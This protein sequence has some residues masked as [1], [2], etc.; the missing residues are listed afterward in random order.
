MR[1]LTHVLAHHSYGVTKWQIKVSTQRK[2]WHTSICCRPEPVF[3]K[4]VFDQM[5]NVA[6]TFKIILMKRKDY[7]YKYLHPV[8]ISFFHKVTAFQWLK[9]NLKQ[10]VP[11]HL[12][13]C[14]LCWQVLPG[15]CSL[16]L[17]FCSCF[18]LFSWLGC[19]YPHSYIFK[20]SNT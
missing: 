6:Q 20:N 17:H 14:T 9:S 8:Y 18:P 11:G 12:I 5:F 19:P 2:K 13:S 3:V 4:T 16:H 10:E 7:N 15:C 1:W